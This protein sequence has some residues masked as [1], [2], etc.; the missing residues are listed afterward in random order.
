MLE[1]FCTSNTDGTEAG[2]DKYF[3]VKHMTYLCMKFIGINVLT[4]QTKKSRKPERFETFSVTL[5]KQLDY[6]FH[7]A[8]SV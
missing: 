1:E 2:A 4:Y 5:M 7:A 6:C 8:N 3:I